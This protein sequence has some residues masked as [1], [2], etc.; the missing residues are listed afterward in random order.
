MIAV[1]V[2]GCV[3]T[4][5]TSPPP[6]DTA[7]SS[8]SPTGDTGPAAT[9]DACVGEVARMDVALCA[10]TTADG[11]FTEPTDS[12]YYYTHEAR[13]SGTV[14]EIGGALAPVASASRLLA[15]CGPE[16]A[17]Q[18]RLVDAAGETWTVGWSVPDAVLQPSGEGLGVGDAVDLVV[19]YDPT[20]FGPPRQAILL[21]D[22]GGPRVLFETIGLLTAAERGGVAAE[23]DR[24]D[25]CLTAEA[26]VDFPV[27]EHF[28]VTLTGPAG[29]ASLRS[30]QQATIAGGR[31]LEVVVTQ[32][33]R[34]PGCADGCSASEMGAW[35]SP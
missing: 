6:G 30:G 18:V 11:G 14:T 27:V 23:V 8:A 13:A 28:L 10:E 9:A 19:R 33:Y 5:S 1:L 31:N 26:S 16:H 3:V 34:W 22:V 32:A 35:E 4:A 2:A 12:T 17:W 21:A 15:A 7:V 20:V 24:Q 25:T 29:G